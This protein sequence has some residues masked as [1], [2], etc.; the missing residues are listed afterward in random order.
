MTDRLHESAR[1]AQDRE[2]LIARFQRVRAATEA[3]AADLA[4]EDQ[5][6]QSMPDC[7][8]TN[9]HLAHTTWF[10]EAFILAPHRPG[11]E[12]AHPQFG[13]LFNS[14][15][16]AAGARNP[17][18]RRGLITRP[19]VQEVARYR[20]Q[21]T[22]ALTDFFAGLGEGEW[23]RLAPFLDLGISHEEQHQ[24][25]IL[26]DILNLFSCNPLCPAYRPFRVAPPREVRPLDWIAFDGGIRRIGHEGA[27][28]AYDN[29]AP[30]HDALIRPFRLARRL[31]TNAEWIAFIEDGG[32]SRADLWLSDGWATVQAEGWRAPLYWEA[33]D[34]GWAA[35]T[36]SG[37]RPVDLAAPVA[38]VSYYE[39]DAYARWAGKRLPTETEWEVAASGLAPTGNMLS[40]GWLRP[41]PAEAAD[42]PAQMFGD[43]WEWTASPYGPYPGYK[44]PGGAIGEYNGKFMANQFV[45]RGGCCATPDGHVRATY[46]N[47]FYPHQRWMFSGVRLAGDA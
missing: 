34:G 8:P 13:Y 3:L 40:A 47:F 31:V 4:P 30:A 36:L 33:A 45:L 25:L 41:L 24:E 1:D 11:Y 43:L 26:M 37:L 18:F 2:A 39:V 10:F 35:M 38:H 29:E 9:W 14:Y 23:A 32:Y 15:Y 20:A 28:F 27:G 42:G 44:P 12:P 19:T 22:E 16:E 17:R 21:V 5:V 6:V 7:S 46:R